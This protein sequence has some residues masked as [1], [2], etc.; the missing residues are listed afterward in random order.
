MQ[1]A[2]RMEQFAD[3]IFTELLAM[4]TQQEKAGHTV[5]DLSVGTPNIP[6]VERIRRA[7]ADA[8]LD[9]KNYVYAIRDT[10][11]LQ[12]AAAVWYK[13]RYGVE[14]DPETQ[15]ESLLGSQEGLTH[16]CLSIID[17]GETVLVPDPCY[18]AFSCG[19][20]VADGRLCYMPLKKENGY[21]I[22]FDAIDPEDAKKAKLMIVS[23]PN[24]PTTAIAPDS[25]YEKLIA[26]AKK[27]DIIVLHDNAY[28]DLV[29]DGHTCGSFLRFPGAIDVGVEFNSLSKTYGMAGARVGFC[30]GN[31][32]VVRMLKTLKS[33]M[34]YGMFLPI[35][36][37]A[38][39]AITGDQSCVKE[40]CR[41]YETRRDLLISLFGQ[42]GW[43]IDPPAATMFVWAQ[44]PAQFGEDDRAFTRALLE[45]AQVLVTP[46]SAFG[47]HGVGHV[48]MALVQDE[49]ALREASRRMAETD[50]FQA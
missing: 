2:K 1:F 8:A 47:P 11:A 32:K 16:I 5:I 44:I 25:F 28:S 33:N 18:P 37:A 41:A 3:G 34:D 14:L 38:I 10:S 43:H 48:R 40:T 6:P 4:K 17:P 31:E 22:D 50:L 20:L 23:Y 21:L 26:F 19:P 24:N 45:K 13:R 49:E 12:K 46:G 9:P 27:Y 35:Q 7:L 30:L 29:F 15:I 42:F 36:R 39:E